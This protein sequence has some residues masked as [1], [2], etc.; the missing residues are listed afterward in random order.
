MAAV[1]CNLPSF[2]PAL[3][4]L[5]WP[6][7]LLNRVSLQRKGILNEL[8][9]ILVT[10]F[11]YSTQ[12]MHGCFIFESNPSRNGITTYSMAQ[13]L[14]SFLVK[15]SRVLLKRDLATYLH[16]KSKTITSCTN[17]SFLALCFLS[18]SQHL[19]V[20]YVWNIAGRFYLV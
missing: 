10:I 18:I 14:Q 6:R 1:S 4:L 5:E 11:C 7:N 16:N 2:T 9:K 8:S 19:S 15:D 3:N 20:S 12:R 13:A 17:R